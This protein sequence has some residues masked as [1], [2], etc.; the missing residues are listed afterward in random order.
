MT[1]AGF[2]IPNGLDGKSLLPI[3]KNPNVIVKEFAI[4]QY[5]RGKYLGYD[6]KKEIMG[7]SI[8][9]NL[10]YISWQLY[11]NKNKIF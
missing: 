4:S 3:L 1:Y 2:Q 9:E 10:R 8:T 11:E 7:Y 5:P 6:H